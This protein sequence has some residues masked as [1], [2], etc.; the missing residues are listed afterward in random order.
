MADAK[1]PERVEL[2]DH[3]VL[4]D[5]EPFP[6]YVQD[7]D[8]EGFEMVEAIDDHHLV[9]NLRVLFHPKETTVFKDNRKFRPSKA[10]KPLSPIELGGLHL[11]KMVEVDRGKRGMVRGRLDRVDHHTVNAVDSWSTGIRFAWGTTLIV[12]GLELEGLLDSTKVTILED[13]T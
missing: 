3:S 7:P 13:L 10:P 11:G 6:Y 4:I 2:R 1:Y 8:T 5:G 9:L 12:G